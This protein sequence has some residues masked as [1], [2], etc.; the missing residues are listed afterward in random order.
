MLLLHS[1][2]T[3]VKI[4]FEGDEI[5]NDDLKDYLYSTFEAS[6]DIGLDKIR[7][8]LTEP[9]ATVNIQQVKSIC[10]FKLDSIYKGV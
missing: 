10:N 8:S 1:V 2:R 9:V 7:D 6:I 4:F 3:W 5:L